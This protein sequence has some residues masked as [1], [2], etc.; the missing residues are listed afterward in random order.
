MKAFF[1]LDFGTTNSALSVNEN[2]AARLLDIDKFNLASKTMRSILFFDE[3]G[4][5]FVGQNAIN[6]YLKNG[7]NG[8]LIQSI[9]TSLPHKHADRTNICGKT[10][11]IEDL[12]TTILKHIK[13]EG[14]RHIGSEINDV[15]IGRPAVF[16]NDKEEDKLAEIRLYTAAQYAGFK[17]IRFQ[18][19]PIA[20]AL[21][22]EASLKNI[23]EKNIFVGD[24]GG[25]TSDFT[26]IKLKGKTEKTA[27][28]RKKDVLSV[29][30]VSV[31]GDI[32]DSLLMWDKL[33]KYF[34]R[35]TKY[36]SISGY[37]LNVPQYIIRTI[38]KWHLIPNLRN[39]DIYSDLKQIRLAADDKYAIQNLE[40]LIRGNY[41]LM[42]FQAI[43]EA[44]YELSSFDK[45]QI[46]Y[47]NGEL[48]IK[49]DITRAEF[50]KIIENELKKIEEYADK[51][52]LNSGLVEKEIDFVF[53]TGGTS[54]IPRIK[55]IFANKFGAEK[56]KETD[57][58][59]TVA[60]G[61]GLSG[62]LF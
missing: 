40:T 33:T 2:G 28:D 62:Y 30:G 26:V 51:T 8:R 4:N 22:F 44:K 29:D 57:A 34:G 54:Y 55:N 19:E 38:C 47:E 58:F 9:K 32:F 48:K 7:A 13:K 11:T 17:N 5:A 45:S 18:Y 15:V 12:I 20:A 43:E 27:S 39:E 37:S 60:Y 41:A 35:N 10:Y 52:L 14:E 49:E 53:L 36:K 56:I 6:E 42:L 16:S 1:G 25:G 31:G 59:T 21:S 3:N 50:E 61:L 23:D 46:N 24:F